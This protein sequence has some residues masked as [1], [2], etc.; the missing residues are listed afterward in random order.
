MVYYKIIQNCPVSA[1]ISI[2]YGWRLPKCGNNLEINGFEG[3]QVPPQIE[4]LEE[5]NISNKM[6]VMKVTIMMVPIMMIFDL[7]IIQKTLLFIKM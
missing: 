4:S 2:N 7:K 3:D 6:K 1:Y 5:T